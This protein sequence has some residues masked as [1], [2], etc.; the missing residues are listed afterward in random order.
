MN[1]TRHTL[2]PATPQEIFRLK[3]LATD[4][5]NDLN[6]GNFMRKSFKRRSFSN[7]TKLK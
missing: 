1:E 6:V 5:V 3:Q 4:A 2:F 7:S